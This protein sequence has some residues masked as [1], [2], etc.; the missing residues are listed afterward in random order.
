MKVFDFEKAGI[1]K[2]ALKVAYFGDKY[3][4]F[5]YSPDVNTVEGEIFKALMKTKL[6]PSMDACKFSRAGRTD[7][8][9]S[10]FG[11]V[12]SVYV[13]SVHPQSTIGWSQLTLNPPKVVD[14]LKWDNEL[15]YVEILNRNLPK[16]IRILAWTPV[17]LDFDARFKCT[18]RKYHYYFRKNELD[19]KLMNEAANLFVGIHDCRNICKIDVSKASGPNY[20]SRE[21]YEAYIEEHENYCIFV[22]KGRAFL[23]HQVR[24]MMA[25]LYL[26]GQK[27]ETPDIVPWLLSVEGGRPAYPMASD[28]PLVLMDC[29]YDDLNWIAASNNYTEQTDQIEHILVKTSTDRKVLDRSQSRMMKLWEEEIDASYLKIAQ[30]EALKSQYLS[31]CNIKNPVFAIEPGKYVPL[32]K[33]IRCDTVETAVEKLNKKLKRKSKET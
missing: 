10:G 15:P 28:I 32:A 17:L 4:G 26:V 14:N 20:F 13:R 11:Q 27:V 2:I 25:I 3:Y 24:C 29:G 18:F 12:C 23:W 16:D 7:K 8:G 30:L 6:V 33:R 19:L 21:I 9:V 31:I 5:Q 22:V 1:R